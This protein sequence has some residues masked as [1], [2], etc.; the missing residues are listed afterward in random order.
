VT[1][2]TIS[3]ADDA[4][5]IDRMVYLSERFPFLEW[6]I[7]LSESRAGTDR[8]PSADWVRA[9]KRQPIALSAH[10]CGGIARVAQ[11]GLASAAF[12][13]HPAEEFQRIQING[14]EAGKVA[15]LPRI[16]RAGFEYILQAND[17]L[18]VAACALDVQRERVRCSILF[19]AS[20]GTGKRWG[21]RWPRV[22]PG[23]KM[24]YAGGINPHNVAEQ[25]G[26]I[27]EAN[28]GAAPAWIDMESGVRDANGRLDLAAVEAVLM[29]VAQDNTKDFRALGGVSQ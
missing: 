16:Q 29:T 1:T 11:S 26:A 5:R 4:V 19:D 21:G 20:G 7:L 8:Y 2:V 14:Y 27:R 6:G 12:F 25:L 10:L 9:L 17:E 28:G 23:T 22:L 18:M 24:G 15:K 3:G 13:V